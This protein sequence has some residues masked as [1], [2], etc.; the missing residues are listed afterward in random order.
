MH[1]IKVCFIVHVDHA[2]NALRACSIFT[3]LITFR[4]NYVNIHFI[5]QSAP[6]GKWNLKYGSQIKQ[7][8]DEVVR[9]STSSFVPVEKHWQLTNNKFPTC[10]VIK[11]HHSPATLVSGRSAAPTNRLFLLLVIVS[12]WQIIQVQLGAGTQNNFSTMSWKVATVVTPAPFS[13]V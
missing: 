6:M 3:S 11:V 1:L 5:I 10:T 7:P 2:L 12:V 4:G 9:V 8:T 13:K